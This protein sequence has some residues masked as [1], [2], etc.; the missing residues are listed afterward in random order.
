[1]N[2]NVANASN[3]LKEI[4]RISLRDAAPSNPKRDLQDSFFDQAVTFIT[5]PVE[6]AAGVAR[7]F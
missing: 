6:V 2:V 4:E 1:L 5:E 7:I 3:S